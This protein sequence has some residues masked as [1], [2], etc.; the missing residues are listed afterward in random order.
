MINP[1]L[2][3]V[4]KNHKKA[5]NKSDHLN[6]FYDSS[7]KILLK[8]ENSSKNI[9]VMISS[10]PES[11]QSSEVKN[12]NRSE[13]WAEESFFDIPEDIRNFSD[14]GFLPNSEIG[15]NSDGVSNAFM[16]RL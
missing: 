7:K 12:I 16:E 6:Y 9:K 13:Q 5:Y 14:S 10:D 1:I 15:M 8:E 2:S 11:P 3:Q 4:N